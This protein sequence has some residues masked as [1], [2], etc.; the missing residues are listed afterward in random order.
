MTIALA[1]PVNLAGNKTNAIG[2]TTSQSRFPLPDDVRGIGTDDA[3]GGT[4]DV[5]VPP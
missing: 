2:S 1:E 5:G 3:D 4:S